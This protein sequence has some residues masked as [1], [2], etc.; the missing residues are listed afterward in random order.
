MVS[1]VQGQ[2]ERI[3]FHN[4]DNG[5]TILRLKVP[6]YRELVTLVG[7][8]MAPLP[9]QVINATGEWTNHP[10]FGEQFKVI[11]Y[12]TLV[13][14]TVTGIEKYLGSGLVKGIGPIM[15]KRIVKLFGE[16]T[17]VII[18]E[19]TGRLSEVEGIGEKRLSMI[20]RAWEDQKHVREVMVFLQGHGVSAGYAAKIYKQYGNKSIGV[21]EE[22]PYRL[23]MDIFGIGF[24]TADR[25]AQNLGFQK[26]SA[27]RV[28]AGAI[29][30]LSQVAEEGHVYYPLVPLLEKCVEILEV[31]QNAITKALESLSSD[32]RIVIESLSGQDTLAVY[33]STFYMCETGVASRVK[34]LTRAPYS[35]RK[36]DTEKAVEWVEREISMSLAMNQ[37]EA[38]KS[39]LDSKIMVITGGPGTGKT[40]IIKAILAIFE[41]LSVE[42]LLAAPT[43]RAAKRMS[44]ATGREAKTIHRM[45][46]FSPNKGGFQRDDKHPLVCDL[47]IIDEASMIDTVLMYN[48]LKAV[49]LHSTLILIGDVNQLPSVGPGNV[50]QDIIESG[51]VPVVRLVEIFRQAQD[52]S[53]IVNAH[54]INSGVIPRL[55]A[56]TEGWSDFYFI[57]K[58]EPEEALATILK[59]VCER[60]QKAFGFD[61]IDD[62]QILT[63]MNRGTVGASNLNLELQKALNP[64]EE[65]VMRGG[66]SFRINDKVMQIRN[67][68]DK[69]VYNGDIGR[70]SRI[71]RENQEVTILFDGRAVSYDYP[72]LD[73]IVLAYAVSVHKSQGSEYPCV[74]IP[75][76]TQH[77]VLLQR[78][79]LYTAITRGRKLV[80]VVGSKKAMA[81]AVKNDKPQ[82]RYT[83]LKE[84]LSNLLPYRGEG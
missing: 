35:R 50:L 17:L 14:A 46:E 64:G 51:A 58:N 83:F 74:V 1:S 34:T 52:S 36:V 22:N 65:G 28:Q 23:A 39:A 67:N 24:V 54:L 45:L 49:P 53:I 40:T 56:S 84:R 3:T 37:I 70:I 57:E 16:D 43:G 7:N 69:D 32:K 10:Q 41:R 19:S 8:L 18:D 9:G 48:L 79:L 13:P 26:D 66:R 11:Q 6:G 62:V 77:Y 61:P 21:V 31:D 80:I 55:E 63:P 47:L 42:I 4:E 15:A 2:I 5:F 75:L 72:D 29:Y 71:D 44:E 30:V 25:I 60:I 68:Y 76:L 33:L 27:V 81:I 38:V 73:E 12:K 82:N 20:R 59:L 78:N